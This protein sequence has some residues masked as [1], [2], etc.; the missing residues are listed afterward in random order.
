MNLREAA[1]QALEALEEYSPIPTD[2]PWHKRHHKAITA[3]RAALAETAMQRLT[4]V[5]QEMDGG[6]LPPPSD[7]IA[8]ANKMLATVQKSS[9]VEATIN[10]METVERAH[11]IVVKK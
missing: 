10:E 5:Q 3:L 7:Y 9:A 11:G 4:D 2:G 6:K 8:D 1:Q